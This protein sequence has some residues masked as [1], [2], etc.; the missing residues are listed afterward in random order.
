MSKTTETTDKAIKSL[1]SP[2]Y[3]R[4]IPIKID[5]G[6]RSIRRKHL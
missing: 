5:G 6:F 1:V 3:E 2:L 4:N